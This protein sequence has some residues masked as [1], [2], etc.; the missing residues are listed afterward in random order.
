[1]IGMLG[2]DLHILGTRKIVINVIITIE[3]K[4]RFFAKLDIKVQKLQELKIV[5][6]YPVQP[7]QS[8]QYELSLSIW[9]R[10]LHSDFR[11]IF[12][13]FGSNINARYLCYVINTSEIIPNTK[14]I[15]CSKATQYSIITIRHFFEFCNLSRSLST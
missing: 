9:I 6:S 5:L 13:I 12:T 10:Y 1:M 8:Y 14:L 4:G 11:L 7:N 15:L 2:M 3:R